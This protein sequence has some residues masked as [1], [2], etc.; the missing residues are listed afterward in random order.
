[1]VESLGWGR[2]GL[3]SGQTGVGQSRPVGAGWC[4]PTGPVGSALNLYL[5]SA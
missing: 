4:D 2:G 5:C 1:M 3:Y